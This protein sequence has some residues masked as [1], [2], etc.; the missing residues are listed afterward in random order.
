MVVKFVI[1]NYRENE[2]LIVKSKQI[3]Q[4]ADFIEG[5]IQVPAHDVIGDIKYTIDHDEAFM[6]DNAEQNDET[7]RNICKHL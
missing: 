5:A 7:E 2:Q 6:N 3:N 1:S 4:K